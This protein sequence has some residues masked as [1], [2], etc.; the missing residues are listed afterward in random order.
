MYDQNDRG[1]SEQWSGDLAR[2]AGWSDVPWGLLL[3][4]VLALVGGI[5]YWVAQSRAEDGG[6]VANLKPGD[7]LDLDRLGLP[8]LPPIACDGPHDGEVIEIVPTLLGQPP[9]G[10]CDEAFAAVRSELAEVDTP[11]T[12]VELL[13]TDEG[14]F[15]EGLNAAICIVRFP[16][17]Y[18]RPLDD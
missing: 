11:W 2:K 14:Y 1:R 16:D 6:A 3:G 13:P 17:T 9:S 4:V 8:R 18:G 5:S 10:S 12:L 15:S 7:C